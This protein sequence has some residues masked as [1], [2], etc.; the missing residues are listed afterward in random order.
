MFFRRSRLNPKKQWRKPQVYPSAACFPARP[1]FPSVR[2]AADSAA[3]KPARGFFECPISNREGSTGKWVAVCAAF[4]FLAVPIAFCAEN[5]EAAKSHV[6]TFDV[7]AGGTLSALVTALVMWLNNKRK[8]AERQ[9]PLGEDVARTYA[10]KDEL[11]SCRL[12]C[13]GDITDV[14]DDIKRLEGKVENSVSGVHRRV[15]AMLESQGKTNKALGTLLG[16]IHSKF[17]GGIPPDLT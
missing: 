2:E 17:K 1:R 8:A 13:R 11:A 15:D 6:I 7:V 3:K 9:P 4:V 12:L 16:V 10:T 5:G 14:R